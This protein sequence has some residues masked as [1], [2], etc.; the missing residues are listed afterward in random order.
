MT[1][2]SHDEADRDFY[3][4]FHYRVALVND[5]VTVTSFD[6]ELVVNA[7]VLDAAVTGYY[8]SIDALPDWIKERL[9]V[10]MLFD[11]KVY[12]IPTVPGVGRRISESV[13]W[14]TPPRTDTDLHVSK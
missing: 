4:D 5:G 1:T 3:K 10:L 9:A 7:P 12:P 8:G 11:P 6:S 2:A 13:F 14:V